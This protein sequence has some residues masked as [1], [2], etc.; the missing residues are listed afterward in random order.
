MILSVDVRALDDAHVVGTWGRTFIQIWR[1]VATAKAS[2]DINRFAT[3][4][5]AADA[6]PATSLFIVEP[7]SPAPE[8]ET[9]KNFA[10]FSRDIVAKMSLAVIVSE[11]GGFRGALVRAVGVTLTTMIPHRSHFKFVNDIDV[12]AQLIKPHLLPGSGGAEALIRAAEE[13]RAKIGTKAP[14]PARR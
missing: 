12:A 7:R 9:R 10:T 1:G 8:D 2:A 13:L 6:F 14:P 11:G 4:F 3:E 5:V